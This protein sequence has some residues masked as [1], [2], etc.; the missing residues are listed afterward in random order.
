MKFAA[1][2]TRNVSQRPFV[3]PQAAAITP[4]DR[5][6]RPHQTKLV[7]T[8]DTPMFAEPELDAALFWRA[9]LAHPIM[10]T[11]DII[12]QPTFS[13]GFGLTNQSAE[14]IGAFWATLADAVKGCFNLSPA[15]RRISIV[16]APVAHRVH[17]LTASLSVVPCKPRLLDRATAAG[18]MRASD[19][20]DIFDIDYVGKGCARRPV[21]F[22]YSLL[23]LYLPRVAIVSAPREFA[24]TGWCDEA[25]A[26]ACGRALRLLFPAAVI[27]DGVDV[28][29]TAFQAEGLEEVARA[30]NL[31]HEVGAPV[32]IEQAH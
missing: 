26:A 21:A 8:V 6:P 25:I 24:E 11:I 10:Q 31:I 19:L 14:F 3:P 17:N 30:R 9:F 1:F 29:M 12:W 18:D 15:L 7:L 32:W 5:R 22:A 4:L 13:V 28:P 2:K 20:L 16:L 23:E 27:G